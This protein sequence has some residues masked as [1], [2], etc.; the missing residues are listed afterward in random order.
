MSSLTLPPIGLWAGI[1]RTVPIGEARQLAGEIESLGY[2]SVWFPESDA[3]DVFVHIGMLLDD[4]EHLTGGTAVANVWGRDAVAMASATRTLTEAYP[5]RFVVG[6]GISHQPLVEGMRGHTYDR[7]L[8]NMRAYL[9]GCLLY[10]SPS[11]RDRQKSRMP[12]SA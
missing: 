12:S 1:L 11:P 9:D 10:T 3:R 5:E 7:P 6:L 4:T 2:G 8:A